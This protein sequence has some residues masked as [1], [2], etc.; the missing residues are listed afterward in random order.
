M[1]MWP[2]DHCQDEAM[3][4]AGNKREFP[5][6]ILVPSAQN[7]FEHFWKANMNLASPPSDFFLVLRRSCKHKPW[8]VSLVLGAGICRQ[9]TSR[10]WFCRMRCGEMRFR[11]WATGETAALPPCAD[12]W[13]V[14]GIVAP[15]SMR[16]SHT[17]KAPRN[18]MGS[19]QYYCNK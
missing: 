5:F 18:S 6:I 8:T 17:W 13:G 19:I 16:S 12:P 10:L 15:F 9:K 4:S 3:L 11:S 7:A 14:L 2:S 1:K